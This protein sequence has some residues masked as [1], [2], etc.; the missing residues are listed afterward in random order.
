MTIYDT[1]WELF[2]KTGDIDAYLLYKSAAGNLIGSRD[3]GD[4]KDQGTDYQK[5]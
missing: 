1:G 3:D 2:S 4:H 5:H